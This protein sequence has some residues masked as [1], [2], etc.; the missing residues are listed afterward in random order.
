[1][2]RALLGGIRETLLNVWG[3]KGLDDRP[4][5]KRGKGIAEVACR[6]QWKEGGGGQD[7]GQLVLTLVVLTATVVLVGLVPP[8]R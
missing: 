7:I 4:R 8:A 1:M 6:A 2:R 3:H 5:P